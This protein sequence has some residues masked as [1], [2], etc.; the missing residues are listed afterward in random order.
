MKL[1]IIPKT[2]WK[3]VKIFSIVQENL[4]KVLLLMLMIQQNSCELLICKTKFASDLW[5]WIIIT[6]YLLLLMYMNWHQKLKSLSFKSSNPKKIFNN[7][8]LLVK[9]VLTL[10]PNYKS[11]I[12]KDRRFIT[13]YSSLFT[14]HC[15]GSTRRTMDLDEWK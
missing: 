2:L 6:D 8:S 1:L 5:F 15:L 9:N 14:F 7:S 13:F 3:N 12:E 4:L 11:L 10:F